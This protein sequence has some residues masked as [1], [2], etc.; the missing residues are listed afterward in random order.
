MNY[1]ISMKKI[2]LFIGSFLLNFKYTNAHVGYV[3]DKNIM[4]TA[5][6]TDNKFLEKALGEP[7]NLILII[8]TITI[9][10]ILY[11]LAY[12]IKFTRDI[13]NNAQ[14]KLESYENIL[15]WIARL[16]I[17]IALMGASTADVLISPIIDNSFG[18]AW[19]ELLLGFLLL[20]GMFLTPVTILSI[21]LFIFG[22][23]NNFYLLGNLEFISLLLIILILGDGRPGFDDIFGIKMSKKFEKLKKFIPLIMRVG[24]GGSMLFLAIYEKFLNPRL[25]ELVVYK[26]NLT[27]IINV[28][29]NMWVLSAG[30]IELLIGIFILIGF[31][32]RLNSAIAFLVITLTFFGLKEDVF[33]HITLFGAFSILLIVGGGYLS[34]DR[35][36]EKIKNQDRPFL[37]NFV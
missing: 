25:S 35:K 17:G 9:I 28:S 13:I 6:G 5:S 23:K 4:E 26:Y 7:K 15:P 27:N 19:L 10:F 21:A 36:K 32:T 2:L 3:I 29:S 24:L 37:H 11:Y 12:K 34:F 31:K 18:I 30:I 1:N 20:L 22:L 8:A 33:S 16:S 14:K